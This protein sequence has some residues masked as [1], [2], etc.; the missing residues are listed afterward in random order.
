MRE[1]NWSF[2]CFGGGGLH[3]RN[4][5]RRLSSQANKSKLFNRVYGLT[6][7]SL[8]RRYPDF[9]HQHE[10]FISENLRGFGRWIWKPYLI[11]KLMERIKNGEGLFYLDSGSYLNFENDFALS[12]FL[13]YRELCNRNGIHAGQL[14]QIPNI[15]ID[16]SEKN[17][18]RKAVLEKFQINKLE[19]ESGQVQAAY[20]MVIKNNQNMEFISSWYNN[21]T[22]DNYFNL[23]DGEFENNYPTFVEHRWDQSIFSCLYKKFDFPRYIDETWWGPNWKVNGKQYPIWAMRNR[24]GIDPFQK[25]FRDIPEL[26]ATKNKKVYSLIDDIF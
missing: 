2:L 20:V 19:R 16:F 24:T 8:R 22:V 15:P 25:R 21:C 9:W 3:Y 10:N 18:T 23:L 17:W 4:A 12:K 5:S 26:L 11:L 14:N 1:V 6:D 13:S 7:F